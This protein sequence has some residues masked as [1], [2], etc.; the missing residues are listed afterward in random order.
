MLVLAWNIMQGGGRRMADILGSIDSHRADTVALA[1]VSTGRIAELRSGLR[2]LGFTA[3][4]A[5]SPPLG[6]RGVMIASKRAFRKRP[7]RESLGLPHHRWAEVRF[8][9]K[10][11]TLVCTYF[12]DTGPAIRAFWPK[13]HEACKKL[14]RDAV[15][16]VGDLNSG[17]SALDAQSGELSSNPWFTAMPL[18]GYT[19]LWRHRHRS[20]LEYT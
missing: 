15:L 19:D 20:R 3:F 5:P 4:H 17:Q 9:E 1:E 11:F 6:K 7:S 8:P 2:A 18:L 14:N 13:A 16:L 12:P 10:R